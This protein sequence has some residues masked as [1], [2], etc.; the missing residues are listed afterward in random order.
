M[1]FYEV[2]LEKQTICSIMEKL[3]GVCFTKTK[4]KEANEYAA[5]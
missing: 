2:L 4:G 5:V 3:Y 1:S